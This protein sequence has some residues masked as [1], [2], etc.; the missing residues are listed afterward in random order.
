MKLF[1][2]I[3]LIIFILVS[4]LFIYD[5]YVQKHINFTFIVA[6]ILLVYFLN[7]FFKE[8]NKGKGDAKNNSR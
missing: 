6:L 2:W 5:M 1:V 7:Q 3:Y 4:P 8:R